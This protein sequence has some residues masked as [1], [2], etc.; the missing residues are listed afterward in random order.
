MRRPHCGVFELK[1][2][3]KNSVLLSR[4]CKLTMLL[5]AQV[6][7]TSPA[8][9]ATKAFQSQS[10]RLSISII[11]VPFL[12][13]V[14][15]K[16]LQR[17]GMLFYILS[18]RRLGSIRRGLACYS[19]ISCHALAVSCG[20][21]WLSAEAWHAILYLVTPWQYPPRLGT[22][23]YLLSRLGS[24]S[25]GCHAL[26]VSARFRRGL[27]CY[28]I[29]L[30]DSLAA[31][32]KGLTSKIPR[33]SLG[34]QATKAQVERTIQDCESPSSKNPSYDC[35]SW[36]NRDMQACWNERFPVD[37]PRR[38]SISRSGTPSL[39]AVRCHSGAMARLGVTVTQARAAGVTQCD[40]SHW[41]RAA[42]N[43]LTRPC[44]SHSQR[45]AV[46]HSPR[47]LASHT[48]SQRPRCDFSADSDP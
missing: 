8:W 43:R 47:R 4:F 9:N 3:L 22:L 26:A 24:I 21:Q 33:L 32:A 19:M 10:I 48:E 11:W 42:A 5:I 15:C 27:A 46:H 31:S 23:F 36:T 38:L 13:I 2:T 25:R 6:A 29:S 45:P 30:P 20:T 18:P 35:S 39:A 14:W 17:L 28:S 40:P 16:Y 12:C 34:S 1:L 41:S 37:M 44:P 7:W